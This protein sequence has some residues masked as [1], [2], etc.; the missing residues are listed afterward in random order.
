M[1]GWNRNRI[2]VISGL[3]NKNDKEAYELL[4]ELEKIAATSDVLYKYF[5]DFAELTCD[6]NSFVRTRGFRLVCALVKWD[7]ENKFDKNID[8]LLSILDDKKPIVVRQCLEALH[9]VVLD[10]PEL[11]DDIRQKLKKLDLSKYK[12]NMVPLIE[13]DIAELIN[14]ISGQN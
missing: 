3:K 4:L 1:K 13:R 6:E 9:I 12:H 10:K 5:E 7:T 11:I 14:V 2:D 8:S